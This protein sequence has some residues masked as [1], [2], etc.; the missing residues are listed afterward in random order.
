MATQT[1]ITGST[2]Y[3]LTNS[4]SDI[5]YTSVTHDWSTYFHPFKKREYTKTSDDNN[6]VTHSLTKFV[7]LLVKGNFTVVE[8]LYYEPLI[9]HPLIDNLVQRVKPYAITGRVAGG[10]M[11]YINSQNY[12]ALRSSGKGL[13]DRRREGIEKFGYDPKF[14]SHLV[15]GVYTLQGVLETGK[16]HF[17][18]PEEKASIMVVKNGEAS[19]EGVEELLQ[20]I[21]QKLD[22]TYNST[23]LP[24]DG[25]LKEVIADYY[26]EEVRNYVL[27][28]V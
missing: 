6:T 26:E 22:T 15:R 24:T 4:D 3:G 21:I 12:K 10:Y 8:M 17:L 9:K 1:W 27:A 19:K 18:T 20:D 28:H 2:M 11:G 25:T 13:S 23:E 7:R 5:D 14:A 16:F